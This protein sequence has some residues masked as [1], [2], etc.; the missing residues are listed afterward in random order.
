MRFCGSL[1]GLRK[2]LPAFPY[3][4]SDITVKFSKDKISVIAQR[5]IPSIIRQSKNRRLIPQLLD[6][7]YSYNNF[8]MT[9]Y[10][11]LSTAPMYDNSG[12]LKSYTDPILRIGNTSYYMS[13]QWSER[14][15]DLLLD[16]IW[17]NR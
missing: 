1:L 14:Y 7:G 12:N 3:F 4:N 10:P 8:H 13:A 6:L 16:W 15:I 11:V 5:E 2:K 17:A 9:Q